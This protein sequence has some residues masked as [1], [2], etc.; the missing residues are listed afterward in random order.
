[1]PSQDEWIRTNS[2]RRIYYINKDGILCR[3]K[4]CRLIEKKQTPGSWTVWDE[5]LSNVKDLLRKLK[6]TMHQI[7]RIREVVLGRD[8]CWTITHDRKMNWFPRKQEEPKTIQRIT[9]VEGS[10]KAAFIPVCLSCIMPESFLNPR[11]VKKCTYLLGLSRI[12]VV[13]TL[14]PRWEP[15]PTRILFAVNK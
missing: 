7:W 15:W 2:S 1:M 4:F 9:I 5:K 14:Y 8:E 10:T 3:P 6:R 13:C 11:H 12:Q